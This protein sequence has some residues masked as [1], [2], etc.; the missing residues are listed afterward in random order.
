MNQSVFHGMSANGFWNVTAGGNSPEC[1]VSFIL[2]GGAMEPRC[3]FEIRAAGVVTVDP[4]PG[5]G[6]PYMLYLCSMKLEYLPT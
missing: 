4:K 3:L 6:T 2:S 5:S 1:L